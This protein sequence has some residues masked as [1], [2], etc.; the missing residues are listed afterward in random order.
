MLKFEE[1]SVEKLNSHGTDFWTGFIG[2]AGIAIG[3]GG[4]I[5]T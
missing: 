5:L 1:V 2:G 4:I 3:I